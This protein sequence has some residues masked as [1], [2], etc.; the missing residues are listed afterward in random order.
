VRSPASQDVGALLHTPLH[1]V[2]QSQLEVPVLTEKVRQSVRDAQPRAAKVH[3]YAGPQRP[4]GRCHVIYLHDKMH[5]AAMHRQH[6]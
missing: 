5:S 3:N 4:T 1:A 6:A 2:L